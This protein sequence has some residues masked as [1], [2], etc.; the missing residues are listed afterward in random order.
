MQRACPIR[1]SMNVSW[2]QLEGGFLPA[3]LSAARDTPRLVA[4]K[5][6]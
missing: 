5:P 1:A 6:D 4:G 3:P 2:G